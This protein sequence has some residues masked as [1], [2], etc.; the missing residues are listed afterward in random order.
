M[1]SAGKENNQA[2]YFFL[3]FLESTTIQKS[4]NSEFYDKEWHYSVSVCT[5]CL[6]IDMIE[7]YPLNLQNYF[8]LKKIRYRAA[9]VAQRFSAAF[10][11]GPDPGEPGSSPMSGSLDG[12]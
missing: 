7:L 8:T 1:W 6:N 11:P 2:N 9:R 10:S 4:C 12:A 3:R 5:K